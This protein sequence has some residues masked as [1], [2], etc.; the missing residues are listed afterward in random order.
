M[1]K[2]VRLFSVMLAVML[3]MPFAARA[4]MDFSLYTLEELIALKTRIT[5]EIAVRTDEKASFDVPIGRYT[6]GED[7]PCGT[8]AIRFRGTGSASIVVCSREGEMLRFYM[9]SSG[10]ANTVGKLELLEG[11]SVE[12][13]GGQLAFSLY[14]G[15]AF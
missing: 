12:I 5:E 6:V 3:L 2:F 8:Y 7:I 10:S 4:Q 13:A 11:Q 9:L 1:K 15:L 14:G